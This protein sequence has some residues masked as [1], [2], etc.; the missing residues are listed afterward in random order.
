MDRKGDSE[1][2][3]LSKFCCSHQFPDA[4]LTRKTELVIHKIYHNN[5]KDQKPSGK[6]LYVESL[7]H[8][9]VMMKKS[10]K[11]GLITL[12]I[13][14]RTSILLFTL[15][16]LGKVVT[17]L[18][19]QKLIFQ[20]QSKAKTP[21][22]Y[23]Y[24]KHYYG[25]YSRELSL[26]TS[27]L[28]KEGLLE[29][30]AV[31][32]REHPYWIFRITKEGKKF[33]ENQILPN[34]PSGLV[35]RMKRVLDEYSAYDHYTLTDIVY[36][37][38][39]IKNPKKIDSKL[40]ALTSDIQT[41]TNFWEAIYFPECPAITFFLAFLEYSQEALQK[42]APIKDPV[43]KSVLVGV[44]QELTDIL[45]N[46]A[47]VC[48]KEEACPIEAE[49]NLCR[50]PNPSVHEIF[51]FIE[52]YCERNNILPKLTKRQ[53]REFMTEEEYRRLQKIFHTSSIY[54]SS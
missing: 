26:D 28:M 23:R 51:A 11:V 5:S 34:M 47:Q 1:L 2:S 29:K 4:T 33:F 7:P 37:E 48:S 39:S 13:P 44:C 52:N 14:E 25:P 35:K 53:L 22:C 50:T 45:G 20:V 38:W 31:F 40:Q 15:N 18:K 21:R 27:T 43:I 36:K 41:I 49:E 54:F 19:L 42:V 32:G 12:S 17:E 3:S 6:T 30:E 10:S 46:I 9:V 16:Y 8:L 24:F